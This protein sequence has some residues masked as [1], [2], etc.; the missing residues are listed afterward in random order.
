MFSLKLSLIPLWSVAL[1]CLNTTAA[2]A[3]SLYT[4]TRLPGYSSSMSY[5]AAFGQDYLATGFDLNNH[6]QATYQIMTYAVQGSSLGRQSYAW[7]AEQGGIYLGQYGMNPQGDTRVLGISEAGWTVFSQSMGLTRTTY[8]FNVNTGE[9]LGLG[10]ANVYGINN[11][12]QVLM[13][14]PGSSSFGLFDLDTRQGQPYFGPTDAASLATWPDSPFSLDTRQF[15]SE[16]AAHLYD[17]NTQSQT[18]GR[19]GWT[20]MLWENGQ[21]Y[22][23][24]ALAGF[25]QTIN[26]PLFG[27]VDY[28]LR[29]ATAINDQGQILAIASSG[30]TTGMS[31]DIYLL[32]PKAPDPEP[33]TPIPETSPSLL[34]WLCGLALIRHLIPA[35]HLKT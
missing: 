7:D 10:V 1:V 35:R 12:N 4:A 32:T 30:L 9:R 31:G 34:L 33:S 15:W 27:A 23:L 13:P 25:T 24:N 29:A 21:A 16:T 20:A 17:R 26:H 11:D 5:V 3:V 22:D 28:R 18:V 14:L 19:I 8:A 6:G 2:A